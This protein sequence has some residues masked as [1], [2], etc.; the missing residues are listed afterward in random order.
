MRGTPRP[1]RP[2]FSVRRI[3]PAHA[4]NSRATCSPRSSPSDHPRACGE[5]PQS[6]RFDAALI[7]SS[8]RMRGTLVD[9]LVGRDLDR[10]VGRD[11]PRACGEL[12]RNLGTLGSLFGS[13]PRM[14]GTQA[15]RILV[16]HRIIPA[17]G[18]LGAWSR[19]L[20]RI[21]PACGE[22]S[23]PIALRSPMDHPRA[24]GELVERGWGRALEFGSS[25][26]MRGTHV[27]TVRARTGARITGRQGRATVPCAGQSPGLASTPPSTR[28]ALTGASRGS[29]SWSASARDGAAGSLFRK[30][31][32]VSAGG[33]SLYEIGRDSGRAAF[34]GTPPPGPAFWVSARGI[35][36]GCDATSSG[37]TRRRRSEYR[38][39]TVQEP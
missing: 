26:R 25:P 36:Q 37:W 18:E 24:C 38:Q 14:R 16:E 3:I 17:C 33:R 5:L 9:R 8:P 35:P 1:G 30:R 20:R 22:L 12:F 23:C 11:H 39:T 32:A 19:S 21:S 28:S 10:L 7:G 6:T 15:Q 2:L 31:G 34:F 13:S 29:R 4:G 27:W